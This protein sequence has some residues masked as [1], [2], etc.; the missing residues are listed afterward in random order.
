MKY[1]IQALSAMPVGQ[2]QTPLQPLPKTQIYP[3]RSYYTAPAQAQAL[4]KLT[5]F[6]PSAR[7]HLPLHEL[8]Q[9]N[10]AVF[11]AFLQFRL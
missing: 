3:F 1:L 6:L 4:N 9:D 7:L 11:Q 10:A 2:A 5:D 8:Y